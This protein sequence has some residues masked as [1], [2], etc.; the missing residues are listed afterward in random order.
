[1]ATTVAEINRE[2]Q[3]RARQLGLGVDCG[4][5]G[6]FQAEI[7]FVAEAP[8]E[9]ERIMGMPLVGASGKYL[10][11]NLRQYGISRRQV[12]ISNV[13]KRQLVSANSGPMKG[14][15]DIG[16]GEISHYSS[17]LL[18][19]LNQ[20]PNL[21]Y[22]VCL[23]NYALQAITGLSGVNAYR[24]SVMDV[25]LPNSHGQPSRVVKVIVLFNPAAVLHDA[26][27]ELMFKFDCKRINDVVTGKFEEYEITHHINPSFSDA[28]DWINKMQTEGE[29]VGLDIETSSSET[30]CIGLANDAHEGM[31]INFRTATD[32]R[33]TFDE[34]VRL[35]K[36]TQALV[37]DPDVRLVEQN[38][39]YDSSWLWFFDRIQTRSVWFDTMLAHHTLYP[40]LPHNL[41]FLVTQYTTHPYYKD[42]GKLWKET[43]DIDAE[44]RYNI[45]DTCLMLKCQQQMLKEL[46]SQKMA[47]F[48]F[49]NV[50]PKQRELVRMTVGGVKIDTELKDKIS[51]DMK[52]EVGK[53][54]H[55]Y[56][57]MVQRCTG[58]PEYRP[59]PNSPKQMAELFFKRL[60]LVGRGV[61][62]D[63]E[64][65]S[66]M[67]DHPRTPDDCKALLKHIDKLAEESKFAST[68]AE[69]TIDEDGRV[70]TEYK[71]TGVQ[72][73]PG[74]L[75][76]ASTGWG[77]GANL[78]NQPG[79]AHSMF[80]A[81]EGYEFNYFDLGQAEAR[82]V[83]WRAP[84]PTWMEQFE[85]SRVDGVYDAHR[86]LASQMFNV[87]YDEV[88]TNDWDENGKPTI[89][90][91]AKRCRHALNYRMMP[92][93]LATTLSQAGDRVTYQYAEY[94]WNLY[95][96]INPELQL[97]WQWTVDKVKAERQ[98]FNAFGRRWMLLE[99][100]SDEATESVVAFYPQST[101]GDKVTNI[102]VQCHNDP[103]W[104]KNEARIALNIHDALIA[105]NKQGVGAEVRAIMKK[106]AE[107]PILIEGCDNKIR[108][109]IV[110][111]DLKVS[112]PDEFGVH[113]WSTLGKVK[114]EQHA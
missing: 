8:G 111:C 95:H 37:G 102:I 33:W 100:F 79:R 78:Q 39:M 32:N 4:A 77:T 16:H 42:E 61:A 36:A 98:L 76:S 21:K 70:R 96:K 6:A 69:M 44:W 94:L 88:P 112:Q 66:R 110:P 97:W 89:R 13:V 52:I 114:E 25:Q 2:I 35:W 57:D 62:T 14:K 92:D 86:A 29:P 87:P 49:T 40:T 19:E 9:R 75:S 34:E 101:I 67:H 5:D 18:W 23:G 28:M 106:Y 30:I 50:M 12:Y 43:G 15:K 81:D 1:M 105:I 7:A 46:E 58:D 27:N 113:R 38:G 10:W 47:E 3:L 99:K 74:R 24:G 45:K 103:E 90:Y 73:A 84:I 17:I 55:E 83:G 72:S 64:N 107:E 93:R 65:R 108:E 85:Q 41:G 104:P 26:K 80:V 60:R 68:Y 63:K 54:R 91:I 71:Q 59:N 82:V 53:L 20:L 48:F 31:C 109:L 11:D 22:I 51:E 56:Y